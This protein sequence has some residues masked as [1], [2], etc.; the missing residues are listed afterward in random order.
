MTDDNGK[1]DSDVNSSSV[2]MQRNEPNGNV[3]AKLETVE[4]LNWN[5]MN[6]VFSH[7]YVYVYIM[8]K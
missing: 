7:K 3:V 6:E 2:E 4:S 1:D 8:M 5:C